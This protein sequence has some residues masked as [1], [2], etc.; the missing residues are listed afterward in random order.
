MTRKRL[1]KLLMSE[2][3]SRNEANSL[4]A[5]TRETGIP[6]ECMYFIGFIAPIILA[7]L[8]D[9]LGMAADKMKEAFANIGDN[10]AKCLRDLAERLHG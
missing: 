7:E 4:A 1:V 2:G 3:Y 5:E 10:V 8:S 6:Y 9:A